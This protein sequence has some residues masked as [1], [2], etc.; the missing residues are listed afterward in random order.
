MVKNLLI[1]S[2]VCATAVSES[3]MDTAWFVKVKIEEETSNEEVKD[4]YAM[5]IQTGE[6]YFKG[7]YLKRV[8]SREHKYVF[9]LMVK[10]TS[11]FS[12]PHVDHE[13]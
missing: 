10:E 11:S 12:Y 1:Q 3:P 4:D 9:T 6:S 2:L 5:I 7:K 8:S 13:I